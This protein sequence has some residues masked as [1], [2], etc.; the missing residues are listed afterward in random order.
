MP[1]MLAST[2]ELLT[3]A[4]LP[5][6][7]VREETTDF[8]IAFSN[9]FPELTPNYFIKP[10]HFKYKENARTVFSQIISAETILFWIWPYVLWPL[11]TVH[12]SAETIQGRKLFKSR[13]Y[14]RKYGTYCCSSNQNTALANLVIILKAEWTILINP[15]E[16]LP[17]P[18]PQNGGRTLV[19]TKGQQ[20]LEEQQGRRRTVVPKG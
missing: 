2:R 16:N 13:N 3:T 12:K 10:F 6:I 15:I 7:H 4:T 8:K 19:L 18:V 9:P 14:S 1:A 11:V 17:Q 20:K 5:F